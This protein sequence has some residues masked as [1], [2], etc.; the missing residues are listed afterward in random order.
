MQKGWTF[1]SS[2]LSKVSILWISPHGPQTV[3]PYKVLALQMGNK[4]SGSDRA[5]QLMLM[6]RTTLMLRITGV[7]CVYTCLNT[8]CKYTPF[9]LSVCGSFISLNWCFVRSVRKTTSN[10]EWSSDYCWWVCRYVNHMLWLSQSP[11]KGFFVCLFIFWLSPQSF[12]NH[13]HTIVAIVV[14]CGLIPASS[15][16]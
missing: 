4:Q 6:H 14:H 9:Y 13:N 2:S 1:H 10:S 12:S 11:V 15:L 7:I 8:T 5:T 16:E 3:C